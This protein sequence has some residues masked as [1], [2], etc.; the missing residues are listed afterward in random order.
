MTS[1]T[2]FDRERPLAEDTC[3]VP[4]QLELALDVKSLC[5]LTTRVAPLL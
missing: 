3:V 4:E 1:A 2:E 5:S